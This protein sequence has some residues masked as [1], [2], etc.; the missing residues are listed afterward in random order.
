MKDKLRQV[1]ES[2]MSIKFMT[3]EQIIDYCLAN[4]LE[5]IWLGVLKIH[6]AR[7][8]P[9]AI[10]MTVYAEQNVG[11][12]DAIADVENMVKEARTSITTNKNE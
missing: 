8:E 3:K 5:T 11:Y 6:D 4:T 7:R 12:F 10:P 2:A 1:K 9:G